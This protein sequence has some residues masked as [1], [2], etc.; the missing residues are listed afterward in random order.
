VGAAEW[1]RRKTRQKVRKS[2]TTMGWFRSRSRWG[3]Y[4][5]L[6]ALVVQL[7]LSF[8]HV[9]LE[10][11]APV[12]GASAL[13]AVHPSNASAAAVD[14]AGKETPALADDCCPICTLIHLA[15]ALVPAS[16]LALPQL[17]VFTPV[18]FAVAVEFDLTK[19]HYSSPL[20]ARAPPLA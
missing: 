2:A 13:F 6:F 14:P 5:A 8:G 10:G 17:A 11:G 18:S 1:L 12:S 19:R 15:S 20:G 3:S 7:A 4:L 16:A 9:H